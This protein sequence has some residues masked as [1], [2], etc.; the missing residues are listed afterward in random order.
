MIYAF[1]L[2]FL[3]IRWVDIVDILLVSVLL[4]QVYK[5]LKGSVAVRVLV[6]FL[7]LYLIYLV[8]KAAQMELLAGILGQFMGVGVLAAIIIFSQEIRKFLLILGKTSFRNSGILESIFIWRKRRPKINMNITAVIEAAKSLSGSNTGALM[9]FS[10]NTELKFYADS[11][12][13]LDAFISKRLLISIFNKYSPLHDGAVILYEGRIKAARCLLPVSERDNLPAQ[14][15]LR[16]RAALGMS[17][18]TDTLILIISEETGQM[19]IARNGK[20]DNNLSA[21]EIRKKLNRYLREEEAES[22][23]EERV[24]NFEVAT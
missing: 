6:G 8:V 23:E 16:H 10:R 20:I 7:S 14:W 3:D 19:S 1:K 5:L 13:L 9:V 12:D 21:P 2:G 24:D 18:A 15:G 11:G 4:Y 17:E 22:T